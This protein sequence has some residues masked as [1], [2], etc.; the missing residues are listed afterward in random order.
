MKKNHLA[1][2]SG[3]FNP[4]IFAGFLLCSIGAGLAML[5]FAA[6]PSSGT[7]T[8][9]SG[10]INYT[11]GPFTQPNQSP[12]GLGQLDTGPRCNGSTFPCDSFALTVNIPSGY[13]TTYP[14]A[15][16]KVTMSWNDAGTGQSDYDLYV[17]KG[18]VG[19]LGGST[20]ADYQSASQSNPEIASISPLSEGTST[21]TIKI[22]PYTPTG[23]TVNVKIE[24]VSGAPSSGGGGFPG[25]G[26]ADPTVAGSPRFLNFYAPQGTSAE[27]SDGEFN[28]GFNPHTGRIM[29]M[30]IGP[31]W[32]ITPPELFAKPECCEGLWEDRS[33]TVTDVGL[34]P[35]LWTDQLTGRTFAS[36]STVGAN[37][38]YAYSDDDGD[39][40]F[41]FGVGAPNGGADHETI[42]SGPY[43]A[44][45]SALTTQPP[46]P[47][48][49]YGH[50]VYYCSQDIVGPA[51]C[52]RSDDQGF[53][54][55][56]S[57]L[58]Y[59][60]SG[61]Q[62]CGGLHGHV[63]VAPDGTVWLPVNQCNGNQGG[64]FS[65]NGGLIWTEFVAPGATSQTQGADPSIAIDVNN[66]IYYA[67]VKNEP[68]AQGNPPE[69]HA[70]VAVGNRVG[71]VI[72]WVNDIDVGR[73][74][75][76]GDKG[77]V[78]AAEIE[79]VGG[80]AGRAAVGFLGTDRPGD[81]QALGFPGK[82]Y[83]FIAMTYD[84]GAHWTTVNATPNDPVQSMT[85]IWQQGGGAQ[86]R[87]LLDFNEITV[88]DKG[89]VLYGYSDGCV[90]EGC[91]NGTAAN[92]FVAYMRV[93]RQSGGKS[94]YQQF[95]VNEP[96]APKAP[97]LSGTRDA[98]GSHLTWKVPDNGG[99]NI[100][101]YKI[102]RSGTPGAEVLIATYTVGP[103][104]KP[105]YTDTT[106]DPNVAHYYYTV[107]AVAG[108]RTGPA[109]NEIDLQ[110]V[111]PPPPQNPCVAP[112]ITLLT[113]A[114]GDSLSPSAGTD[115]LSASVAQPY[116]ADGNIKLIFTIKTDP[117]TSFTTAKTPGAGWYLAMK[118]P[119]STQ[120]SG[121]R[122]TGVRMDA[123]ATGPTF[124]SYVPGTN[125]SGGTD[126]RFVDSSKPANGASSYDPNTGTITIVVPIS[127][128][129]LSVG[130][131]V[132]GF[133]AGSTQTSDV[134]N[135]GAG[136][137]EVWDG[138]PDSLAFVG[139]YTVASNQTCR[140]NTPPT[141]VLT[142]SPTSGFAPLMVNFSG[143][144]SSDPD[145][146]APADTIASYTF[147]FGDGNSTTQ[148]TARVSHQYTSPG[149]YTASLTVTDSR[150]AS[151]TNS[152]TKTITVNGQPDLIV[153]ALTASNNQAPQG[154]KVTFTATIKNQGTVAAGA[155]TTQFKD[156]NTVLGS[157]STAAIPANG[158]VTVTFNWYT[159]SAK[160]GNHTITTTADSA[161]VVA[162]SNENNNTKTI[163]VSIQGN[164]T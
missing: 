56:V 137:T 7:L 117:D 97:C 122:Y 112:G 115:M 35:I 59:T 149:S 132:V 155:S 67:Y 148:S 40:W 32:R 4:R 16:V 130:S 75:S 125:S 57:T 123:G 86:Q 5:S 127:D 150:G 143:A 136:A 105:E 98:A 17:Y 31:I 87:N 50:P 25:F 68:V 26:G 33:S 126:G 116:A 114:T 54:W 22:V 131:Q 133:V 92:D 71:N 139:S 74:A 27:S 91:I 43:P 101:A 82:W 88:D 85:G 29:T 99:S 103:G 128:L 80:S 110:V 34:D 146:A 90:T 30:N 95:D 24:L 107:Q 37:A 124:S 151:S 94:L 157:V 135:V 41:P 93:A 121:F 96:V 46:L 60:G 62:G 10:P 48:P 20:P 2:E 79:A 156:G 6:N 18:N 55:G 63:H 118:V 38:V 102:L 77:I 51:A 36:N 23:E 9:A 13:T 164:K 140:P 153:S 104:S 161:K 65:T 152:A 145:T 89:R 28:I 158:S 81:Y 49:N 84:G 129:G 142:A 138:M 154:S 14:N 70:H 141:A 15:A 76:N 144:G 100:T 120:T 1:S 44:A 3:F 61:P 108:T 106:A 160:K 163:T 78:N 12:V 119:D 42:G 53:S 66:T 58:A 113:D 159:A 64:V 45:L 8:T 19:N 11:A 134:A 21:Y 72:N 109:S 111:A 162:E 73:N 147:N 83:A 69:G 52:Y 39:S 47:H